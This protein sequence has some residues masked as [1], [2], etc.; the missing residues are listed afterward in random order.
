MTDA[1]QAIEAAIN[2]V[3]RLRQT[4]RKGKTT[5]VSA[6]DDQRVLK[7]TALTWFSKHRKVVVGVLRD[8]VIVVLDDEYRKLIAASDKASLRT[9]HLDCLK[10]IKRELTRL[11]SEHAVPLSAL[12]PMQQSTSSMPPKFLPLVTDT[13]MQKILENRWN[14]CNKCV[15]AEAPL[16][17]TV[18]MGGLL[19]ALLLARVNQLIDKKAVVNANSAPKDHQTG[20]T[21]NLTKWGLSDF[22]AVAYELGWISP[23][24]RDV[25][26]VVRDYRNYIHPQKEH[27]HGVSIS[28]DDAKT[29]WEIA[30]GVAR[31]VLKP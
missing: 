18:M 27:S 17:A 21:L 15:E 22:I 26:N 20:K 7:A 1:Q 28:A 6:D 24:T 13:G 30:K 12:P 23:T 2:E 19:E 31:Q 3:E 29:L 10:R 14:E 9:R 8:D 4:L 16:A 11:Q 25:G 5:Q